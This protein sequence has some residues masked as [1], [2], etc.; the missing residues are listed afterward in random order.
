MCDQLGDMH[1]RLCGDPAALKRLTAIRLLYEPYGQALGE[2]LK[3]SLPLWIP[4][5]K[6]TDPWK[7]VIGLSTAGEAALRSNEHVSERST[8]NHLN[9][10][11]H[12][13]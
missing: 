9:D 5:P 7:T 11:E 4:E 13:F 6:K 1:L 10:D 12:G 2:Y 3:M 8:A